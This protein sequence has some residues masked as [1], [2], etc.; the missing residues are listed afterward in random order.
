M[1]KYNKNVI[2]SKLSY[3]KSNNCVMIYL[4]IGGGNSNEKNRNDGCFSK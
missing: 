4:D 2:F 3:K 1:Y